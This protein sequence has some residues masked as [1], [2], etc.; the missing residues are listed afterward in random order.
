MMAFL[1][2]AGLVCAAF[3]YF[4]YRRMGY[5]GR[6]IF[7]SVLLGVTL[8]GTAASV[9]VLIW[10]IRESFGLERDRTLA[11]R[12]SA[13]EYCANAARYTDMAFW[14]DN[15]RDYEPEFDYLWERL[16][17]YACR[18]RYRMYAVAE[19][20]ESCGGEFAGKAKAWRQELI[21]LCMQPEYPENEAVAAFWLEE[22]SGR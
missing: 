12:L 14:L 16:Q 17:M 3:Y 20:S 4:F 7:K 21:K 6:L 18:N 13:V 1:I 11:G 22:V 2:G 5:K 9:F 19:E 15:D 8:L 10:S